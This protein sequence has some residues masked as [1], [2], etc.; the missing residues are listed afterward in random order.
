M[1]Q[2]LLRIG[3]IGFFLAW[4]GYSPLL[5]QDDPRSAVLP[6]PDPGE[7][8]TLGTSGVDTHH[9]V[10]HEHFTGLEALAT[11]PSSEIEVSFAKACD[12][13]SWPDEAKDAV[14]FAA[15]IW[16]GHLS[17]SIP[18]RIEAIWD[19]M[20]TATLGRAGPTRIINDTRIP[21]AR[22]NTWYTAA[23]ASAMAD[24][25]FIAEIDDE[26][27]DV[28]MWFNC[29]RT[30]W[31]F[32][33]DGE[34]PAGVIDFVTVVLHEI[35]HG[36]GFLGTMRETDDGEGEWGQP[37]NGEPAPIIYDSFAEDL[38][39]QLLIDEDLYPNPSEVLFDTLRSENVFA[40]GDLAQSAN[41]GTRP[42]L[43]APE[44]WNQGS[45]FS[46][47]DTDTFAD[48]P[49]ALMRHQIDRASAIHSPGPVMCGM[50]A[51]M[52]WPLGSN[53]EDLLEVS[54][55]ITVT[56]SSVD[57]DVVTVEASDSETIVVANSEASEELVSGS[58]S[59]DGVDFSITDGAGEY[60]LEPGE[61]HS[62]EVAFAPTEAEKREATVSISHDAENASSPLTVTVTGEGKPQPDIA[63]PLE[64]RLV[65]S[66][67]APLSIDLESVF[68][69]TGENPDFN[70]ESSDQ[71]VVSTSIEG[72][73]L[74]VTIEEGG[75]ATVTA[76]VDD[77][78]GGFA[79]DAFEIDVNR[80]PLVAN[81]VGYQVLAI[82][83]ESFAKDLTT[84][85]DDPD[86][87]PLAFDASS[88]NTLVASV[89]VENGTLEV[90]Q[91]LEGETTIT[92]EADDGRG[93][94]T[95]DTFDVEVTDRLPPEVV[96][97]IHDQSLELGGS[98]FEI[99]LDEVFES[100]EGDDL[101]YEAETTNSSV[102]DLSLVDALLTVTASTTGSA[103]V[104]VTATDEAQKSTQTEF[105][106]T[107]NQ[108]LV[109]FTHD[110]G[111]ASNQQNYRLLALP[112]NANLDL[113][114]TLSAGTPG[115][116]WRAFRELGGDGSSVDDVLEEYESGN[117]AFRFAA[118][119]GFWILS[120]VDW[121]V[122]ATID[123]FATSDGG[124]AAIPLQPGW[125]I[126]SNPLD[127]DLAWNDVLAANDIDEMLWAWDGG[128]TDVTDSDFSSAANDGRAYYFFNEGGDNA[129]EELILP[130]ASEAQQVS[131]RVTVRA[132]TPLFHILAQ[133][134]NERSIGRVAIG[135]AE[136]FRGYTA[137][138][139][140][141]G[142]GHLFLRDPETGRPHAT[143]LYNDFSDR[144]I[145]FTLQATEGET[146]TLSFDDLHSV[147]GNEEAT[148]VE[149]S[150]DRRHDLRRESSVSIQM[151]EETA[152]L[153]VLFGEAALEEDDS[154]A[155]PELQISR[156]YPNPSAQDVTVEFG[157][158]EP[159]HVVIEVFDVLGRP[160]AR[161]YEGDTEAG[162]HSVTWDGRMSNGS[163]AASGVYLL[164][165]RADDQTRTKRITRLP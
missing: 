55:A 43:Y 134:E 33:T 107:V 100:P 85:F 22:P 121:A 161:L 39:Q 154:P 51:D 4:M 119:R 82:D 97:E 150:S 145:D 128:W 80:A 75:V 16:A 61:S 127:W 11:T 95:S 151:T 136:A 6:A 63:E 162:T 143:Q 160:V 34:P 130:S 101:T 131:P 126:I 102:S 124:Q 31:Y 110:F 156:V 111:D 48:T 149:M 90:N 81:P 109:T 19:D 20:P 30:D 78:T 64:D 5:A 57:F 125:N 158:P 103:T 133:T 25:D 147:I 165:V 3:F 52:G 12:G 56:P 140:V 79:S 13:Q 8:C 104:T 87:D 118:G 99:N 105:A 139:S 117:D 116:D 137:P 106:V 71:S 35:G 89:S 23:Q 41:E 9:H 88:S 49:N 7:I 153:R 93:G 129:L 1:V 24:E 108:L 98:S 96:S 142:S 10:R 83:G 84:V 53:C 14:N 159:A 54:T 46:H 70:G 135:R 68:S 76:S 32:D 123:A 120:S 58:I 27:F 50:L 148:L 29:N 38:D 26:E 122:D 37:R 114:E 164:R 163:P 144:V 42:P 86:G 112:G 59:I 45:S 132:D 66:D 28:R 146:V 65:Q 36:V 152:S 21:D 94:A 73:E 47:L 40:G 92:V 91:Q 60:A 113:A 74:T 157:L 18:I 67:D 77:G 69:D 141:F 72:S 138:P 15:D 62:I 17:S 2:P 115:R 155:P 44:Q